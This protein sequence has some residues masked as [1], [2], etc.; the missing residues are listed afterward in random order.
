VKRGLLIVLALLPF[1]ATAQLP[2]LLDHGKPGLVGAPPN[3]SFVNYFNY[4]AN[5]YG[6]SITAGYLLNSPTNRFS[7]LL[8]AQYF[9]VESNYGVGG[10]QIIDVGE[11]DNITANNSISNNTVSVWFAG[12]NDMRYYGTDSAALTDNF[13]A[14]ES[15]AA[16]LAIPTALRVPYNAT[17]NF[18]QPNNIYYSPNQWTF[19]NN[20]T[21]GGLAISTQ[22]GAYAGFKFS[23]NTLLIGTGR[24]GGA[25]TGNVVV[26]DYINSVFTPVLT[27]NF[28]CLRT[29]ANT[30]ANR[31]YSAALIIITNLSSTNSHGAIFT[32]NSSANTYLCWFAS[33]STNLL[34][35]VV[36]SG[37]LKM[38][39]FEYQ[40][41]SLAPNI[42]GSDLAAD[43]YSGIISNTAAALAAAGLNVKWVPAP[44]L[45]TNTDFESDFVHPNESGH[46]KIKNAIQTAF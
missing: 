10:S 20:N 36:L 41:P 17:A 40:N 12:Y 2:M 28:S 7:S 34:P 19:V 16:W 14:L 4:Q 32:A 46:L 15:L 31:G 18:P 35:K 26:G 39:A 45:N 25:G 23:G 30:A 27:N 43:L 9:L 6:D 1:F 38:P 22:A 13:A 5:F 21:L 33:Y 24:G 42:N 44:V 37:T 11:S 3:Q 29:A 8:S